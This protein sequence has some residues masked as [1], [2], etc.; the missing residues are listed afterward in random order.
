MTIDYTK[1]PRTIVNVDT[2]IVTGRFE[3]WRHTIGHGAVNSL[4]LPEKVIQGTS[5]LKPRLMRVF[6]QE[7]FD[8]YPAHGVFNWTKL[9]AY[10]DSFARTGTKLLATINFKPLVLFPGDQ[11]G[12]LAPEQ[13]RGISKPHLSTGEALLGREADR[14]PLGACQRGGLRLV[15]RLSVPLWLA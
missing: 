12:Y 15:G 10:M 3:A 14:N 7:Y 6:L 11:P 1:L 8:I 2:Q 4:P 9:D 5:K 13:C